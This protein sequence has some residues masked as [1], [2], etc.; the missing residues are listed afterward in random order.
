MNSG[1]YSLIQYCPDRSRME[2]ANVGVVLICPRMRFCGVRTTLKRLATRLTDFFGR[3]TPG[4]YVMATALLALEFRI[5]LTKPYAHTALQ[6]FAGSRDNDLLLTDPRPCR[7]DRPGTELD[8]LFNELVL[9]PATVNTSTLHHY[10]SERA[11]KS[12]P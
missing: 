11:A 1:Y 5:N 3:D 10:D 9:P 2:T 7:F 6:A 8:R 12:A 4:V